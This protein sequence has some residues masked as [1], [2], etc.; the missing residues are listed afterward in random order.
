[1]VSSVWVPFVVVLG[2]GTAPEEWTFESAKACWSPM[3]RPVENVGVPGYTLQCGVMWDGSLLF[4]PT[5]HD[6]VA[7]KKELESL[8]S[9]MQHVSFGFGERCEQ[10]DRVK[11]G[12]PR[13]RRSLLEG[14]LP[15]PIFEFEDGDLDWRE[16]VFA[17]L[18]GR[19]IESGMDPRDDD[20]L[21]IQ[22]LWRVT[23][24]GRARR[25]ARLWIHV[26]DHS[27]VGTSYKVWM[28]DGFGTELMHEWRE[29]LGF[30]AGGLRYAIPSPQ[31]GELR[32]QAEGPTVAGAVVRRC[33]EWSIDLAPGESADLRLLF[34]LGSLASE[35]SGELL[36]V[37]SEAELRK[38]RAFWRSLVHEGARIDTPDAFFNDYLAAV[39]AQMSQQIG[40]RRVARTWM[41]KTAPHQ[42]EIYYPCNAAK[43]LPALDFRG[44]HRF[45]RPVLGAFLEMQTED[46]GGLDR[47][48]MGHGEV[49]KGEGYAKVHG[50][51]GN[52]GDWT[53]N[54]LLLSHGLGMWALARHFRI[55]RDAAWLG[56]GAGST[57][58][59]M[60]DAFDWVAA[61]RRRT[62]REENGEKV[63]HWGML[64]A[65]SAH[66]WLAGNTIFN[67][68][69]CLFGMAEVV[70]A[71]REAGEPN[72]RRFAEEFDDYRRCLRDR[73]R[74]AR[75][76]ALPVP[77]FDGSTIPFVPRM[78]QELDWRN[79]DWTYTGYGP[80]R[81]GAWGVFDPH[82]ALV[83]QALAFL[84]AGMPCG[85][86]A[87]FDAH[88]R[89]ADGAD[90]NWADVSDPQAERHFLWRHYVEYETMW[91]VG[92][93]LFLARDD[94]PR[95]F[96]WLFHNF[97]VVLHR[98]W[99]VGVESLDGVPS[100]APG[101]GER[102]QI[103]RNMFV[104]ER[105]GYDG[106]TENELFLLQAMP[107]SWLR[108]GA[109]MGVTGMGT[110]FGG[111][112][113]VELEVG[114]QGELCTARLSWRDFA[115]L[116]RLVR[117]RLRSGSGAPLS[118]ATVGD[119]P[120]SIGPADTIELPAARTGSFTIVGRF[121]DPP[122]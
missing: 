114:A 78:V 3:V 14:R 50:F 100:C 118:S 43:A 35:R 8:C 42:Y 68:A 88:L 41:Y 91:P 120:V 55:T 5:V 7:L 9:P 102:W 62:I 74:E 80:L 12:D 84:E 109:R 29:P 4:G 64:P 48:H 119:Q 13:A 32:F 10:V 75:D 59:T 31:K 105:G 23:N 46:I 113:D 51:L 19:P 40:F 28:K 94:L 81:A 24:K 89:N 2:S 66:D 69:F 45:S 11:V 112:V 63:P 53:A 65:A 73:T 18:L 56:S 93:P 17:H 110:V 99:R 116:P 6:P 77:L 61:Q 25:G 92:G 34:P 121:G 57:R 30:L 49:L 111:R 52:F 67:D 87:Y 108:P 95:F 38:A 70:R 90:R 85:E 36:A 98:E 16:Q 37:D 15:M 72:A 1:M 58:Q 101:D 60:I 26:G 103:V 107:R 22:S 21:I 117:V 47:T 104:N 122:E 44:L 97:A 33:L 82:D 106:T 71:L 79:I 54:P 86:G 39:G 27:A 20:R 83:E 115:V 76:R 96:E